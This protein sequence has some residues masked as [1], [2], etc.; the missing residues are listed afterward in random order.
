MTLMETLA[1]IAVMTLVLSAGYATVRDGLKLQAA[2]SAE[3][4]RVIARCA[5]AEQVTADFRFHRLARRPDPTH[6]AVTRADGSVVEYRLAKGQL[7]RAVAG[8]SKSEQPFAAGAV[9]VSFLGKKADWSSAPPLS[10]PATAIR[11]K[12][13]DTEL[14]VGR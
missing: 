5:L 3:S 6:F 8:E 4:D 2:L 7:M 12:F 11:L 14:I 9:Q 13:D 10:E 1:A